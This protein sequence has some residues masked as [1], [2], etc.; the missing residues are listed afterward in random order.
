MNAYC[1]TNT[2][3]DTYKTNN[4]TTWK[5]NLAT[6]GQINV[7]SFGSI[8]SNK[9]GN[10]ITLKTGSGEYVLTNVFLAAPTYYGQSYQWNSN[11]TVY[12]LS[13]KLSALAWTKTNLI[14]AP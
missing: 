13:S 2:Y 7:F 14:S 12:M 11:G 3:F 5:N 4:Y 9:V 8:P 6:N 10:G 1:L